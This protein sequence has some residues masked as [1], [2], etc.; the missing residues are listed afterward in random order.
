M[1]R[2]GDRRGNRRG[3]A[4][5][6]MRRRECLEFRKSDIGVR[7]NMRIRDSP[8]LDMSGKNGIFRDIL[9]KNS[10]IT[11]FARC[12]GIISKMTIFYRVVSNLK[13]GDS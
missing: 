3:I 11:Y 7:G 9:R 6:D 8:V 4:N 10:A 13:R 5:K 2:D 1:S 12:D